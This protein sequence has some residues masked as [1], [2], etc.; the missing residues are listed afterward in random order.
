MI[1]LPQP[2]LPVVMLSDRGRQRQKNEDRLRV[3]A[4]ATD[5]AP[6]QPLL[7]AVLADGMGGHQAGEVAA[8]LAVTKVEEFVLEHGDTLAPLPLLVEALRY[9]S[10]VIFTQGQRNPNQSGMG[11][12]CT[13]ALIQE[14]RLFIANVGDSRVYLIRNGRPYRLSVDHTWVQEALDNGWITREEALNHPQAHMIRQ[15]LGSPTPPDVDLRL[16]LSSQESDRQ[17]QANQGLHLEAGDYI[18][19]CSDGLSDLVEDEEMAHLLTRQ[20]MER[21]TR[22]LVDLA[23]QRGGHDNI[24]LIVISVP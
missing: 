9:A 1:R 2:H 14:K 22:L 12:T 3:S 10:Q 20:P 21:A 15:F 8:E 23:N 19:L 5:H 13:C 24:S 7:L 11:A 18:L 16:R 17:A 4:L 6:D